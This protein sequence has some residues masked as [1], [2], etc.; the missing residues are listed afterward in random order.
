GFPPA[1]SLLS[2]ASPTLHQ[3]CCPAQSLLHSQL[4]PP[5]RQA[6]S[7]ETEDDL[8]GEDVHQFCCPASECSSPSSR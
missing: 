3:Y 7:Q 8:E 6:E 1:R 2:S 5:A 4:G